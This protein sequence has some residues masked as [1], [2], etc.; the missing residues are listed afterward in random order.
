MDTQI[1][2]PT[3]MTIRLKGRVDAD[4][5]ARATGR[6]AEEAAAELEAGARSGA[7]LAANGRYRV[8]AEGRALLAHLVEEERK[9]IDSARLDAL[10]VSFDR[11]NSTLKQIVTDWQLR[12]DGS[13][14]DHGDA[15]YDTA[16]VERLVT[17]D[18]EFSAWL[19]DIRHV[20]TRLGHYQDRFRAAIDAVEAGDHS[21][22]AKPIT[23]SYHTVW[24]ELHEELLALTG[25]DRAAEAAAGRAE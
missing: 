16:I 6:P 2:L 15:A 11:H 3:L 20:V 18:R 14:N 24:F 22:I 5:V 4:A 17:L 8:T 19:D 23:D 10:Y 1:S 25:R 12:P 7:L 9:A 21:F 13:P